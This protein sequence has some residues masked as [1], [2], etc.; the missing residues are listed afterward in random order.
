[1]TDIAVVIPCY[2]L[3]HTIEEA[4]DS[5]LDQSR[6]AAEIVIV[7]DGSSDVTTREILEQLVRPR[8][9][10]VRIPHAGVATARNHG[11]S[12]TESSYVVLLDADDVLDRR[13]LDELG[14]RLDSD[15]SL[16]FVS[17]AV[18]AFE[19]ASYT[20][21]PPATTPLGMLTRGSVHVS[22]MFRRTLWDAV[23]GFDTGLQA[24]E[25]L[26]F[27]LQAT[28]L[29]FRGEVLDEP[30]LYYRVR[31]D[32]RYRAGIEPARYEQVIRRI[33][34]RHHPLL[35]THGIEVLAEKQSFVLELMDYHRQLLEERQALTRQLTELEAEITSFNQSLS[36]MRI[37]NIQPTAADD[38]KAAS[39]IEPLIEE[40]Q[41]RP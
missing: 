26:D 38:S 37:E 31:P 33:L 13:Y 25:D 27:W 23:G 20:W 19:G 3:G 22:S 12:I 4:V 17:C 15:P 11:V 10:V 28:R 29:G 14:S 30:L 41:E 5:A 1:M 18:R 34:D 24:Y 7:D 21:K 16:A 9:R 32:S 6:E 36:P 2:N 40:R 39:N 8:T 35:A